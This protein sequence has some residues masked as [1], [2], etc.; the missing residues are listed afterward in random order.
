M[1]WVDVHR[2]K[3]LDAL[4]VHPQVTDNL[5]KI[6]ASGDF[7]H[8]LFC[9]PSGAGKKTR[10]MALLKAHF[11]IGAGRVRLEHRTLKVTESKEIE[12]GVLVSQFHIEVNPSD[13]GIYDRQVVMILVKEIAETISLSDTGGKRAFKVVVLNEVEKLSKGAQQALRRTM[14]RYM[15]TC[16]LILLT[17]SLTRLLPPLRSRCLAIRVPLPSTQ[18]LVRVLK[19]T[20]KKESVTVPDGL[21]VN[22][23]RQSGHNM[24]RAILVLEATK[25]HKNALDDRTELVLPDWSAFIREIAVKI[26]QEQTPKS[27]WEVR[28]KL[29]ELLGNCVPGDVIMQELATHL[30]SHVDSNTQIRVAAIA[31]QFEHNLQVGSKAIVHLEAFVCE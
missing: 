19:A 20:G 12:V 1:L 25:V 17:T 29:Y 10:A 31:A 21:A 30:M 28:S 15:S 3:T 6:A 5:V 27:V 26:L 13:A 7:P 11:G 22:I 24:R 2:P 14:E 23:A 8:L 9:G 16:R 18:D 4:D